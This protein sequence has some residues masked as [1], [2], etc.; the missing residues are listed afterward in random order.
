[1]P[2]QCHHKPSRAAT[3]G[4]VWDGVCVDF[5]AA[6]ARACASQF[7]P[8]Q[9][10]VDST[11]QVTAR[12]FARARSRKNINRTS[13][14]ELQANF[15]VASAAKAMSALSQ[16]TADSRLHPSRSRAHKFRPRSLNGEAQHPNLFRPR[17]NIRKRS[18]DGR[19][20]QCSSC[21]IRTDHP[22]GSKRRRA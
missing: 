15:T 16:R 18:P 5:R 14:L 10:D 11:F 7:P 22:R 17:R 13:G 8:R 12:G 20:L 21:A 2:P 19:L 6:D 4:V 3:S 9:P 1:M